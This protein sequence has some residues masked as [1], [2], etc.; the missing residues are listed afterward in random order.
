MKKRSFSSINTSTTTPFT[1]PSTNKPS[2]STNVSSQSNSKKF[3]K[4]PKVLASKSAQQPASHSSSNSNKIRKID[5]NDIQLNLDDL[6]TDMYPECDHFKPYDDTK[7]P[8]SINSVLFTFMT[9]E[10]VVKHAVVKCTVHITNSTEPNSVYDPLMGPR[11][12]Q[13]K[14]QY[15]NEQWTN[16]PGHFGYIDLA[17]PI[18]HPL[19]IKSILQYLSIFCA[20]CYRLIITDTQIK[21]FGIEHYSGIK[22]FERVLTVAENINTCGHCNRLCF[23]YTFDDGKFLR[24]NISKDKASSMNCI[25]MN[26]KQIQQLFLNIADSDIRQLGLHPKYVHPKMLLLSK[27]PV[28][29]PSARSYCVRADG[30]VGHDD[31]TTKYNEIIKTNNSLLK[32]T[33]EKNQQM[34]LSTLMQH[35]LML[36]DSNKVKTKSTDKVT[37]KSIKQR[38]GGKA[39][40]VRNNIQGK[41]LDFCGRTVITP[42]PMGQV[43][44]LVVPEEIA[45]R[46]T[47]PVKVTERNLKECQQLLN[48]DKVNMILRKTTSKEKDKSDVGKIHVKYHL[49]TEG[50]PL[51]DGDIIIRDQEHI[52]PQKYEL[53]KKHKF[54]LQ[55]GDQILRDGKILDKV[56][57]TKRL[58]RQ[59]QVGDVIER[60]LQDGDWTLFNRQP[61]LWKGSM[62]AKK[63]KILPGKTFRFNLASTQAYNADFDGDE[64]SS[65]VVFYVFYSFF[66]CSFL[67]F[68]FFR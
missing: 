2:S 68:I 24:S 51:L 62:R 32:E 11:N 23:K 43:D 21:I 47:V 44:E 33:N 38:L 50:T 15:C 17:S 49:Y 34:L 57:I 35:V 67:L 59:L 52:C 9:D 64:V 53:L 60:K 40:Q 5:V 61:T 22:R 46:L 30:Q 39:G 7:M 16:C 41:R 13:E 56:K 26:I 31:L 20:S 58:D 14:C 19:K 3:H 54:V 66:C 37:F 8:S 28:L 10:E 65:N 45:A 63:I 25:P 29:P 12:A 42:E 55:E 4:T 18:P 1:K 48:T 6:A 36:M 27:L